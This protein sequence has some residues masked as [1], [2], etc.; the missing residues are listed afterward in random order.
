VAEEAK[1]VDL[2]LYIPH[3]VVATL[4]V[5]GLPLIAV[6]WLEAAGFVTSTLA[7]IVLGVVLSFAAA[8]LGS[9][10]WMR[11]SRGR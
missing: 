5:V 8:S 6:V 4:M 3:V 11:R 2:R 10:L 7:S 9:A 1:R